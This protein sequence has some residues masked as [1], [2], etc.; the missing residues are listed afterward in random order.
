LRRRG[1]FAAHAV[2]G[3]ESDPR[4]VVEAGYTEESGAAAARRL[5]AMPDPPTA[6]FAVTDMVALGAAEVARKL[7]LRI[8]EDL[9]IVGYNDIALASRV[10]PGLTTMHVPIHEFGA[11]AGRLLLDQI[12]SE[13]LTQ[14]RVRF[15]PDLI[16]RESTVAGA[17][18]APR[19]ARRHLSAE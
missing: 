15:T 10:N 13:E 19:T 11:V 7:G 6:V 12:E 18:L 5:L 16:V 3:L 9:A 17:V 14:R 2:A 1:Y 8:P 4:L